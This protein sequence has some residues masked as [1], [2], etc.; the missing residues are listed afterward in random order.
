MALKL[1]QDSDFY[2][3]VMNVIHVM[4]ENNVRIEYVANEF[5]VSDTTEG[6]SE[7]L[8]NMILYDGENNPVQVLPSDFDNDYELIVFNS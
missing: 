1:K 2:M 6:A 7:R 4:E 5:R 8:Q 3:R